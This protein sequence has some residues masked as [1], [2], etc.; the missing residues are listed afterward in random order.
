MPSIE[1]RLDNLESVEEI[2]QLK[3]IYCLHCD[4][5]HN[6][7][8]IAGL[9]IENGVWESDKFGRFEGKAAISG[10]FEATKSRI[11][12]AAHLLMNPII[13]I[14]GPDRAEGRWR[15]LMPFTYNG[16]GSPEPYW[17]A[18]SYADR[19]VRVDGKWYFEELKVVT[20]MFAPHKGGWVEAA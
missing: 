3:A 6:G 14:N 1:E 17:L 18:T 11:T 12:F 20:E 19:F 5:D 16:S 8:A 2:K 10:Y 13:T 15:L 4:D 7:P 9:F